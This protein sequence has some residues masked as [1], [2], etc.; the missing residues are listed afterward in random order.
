MI[1]PSRQDAEAYLQDAGERNPGPWI[2]HSRQVAIAAEAIAAFHPELNPEH[3]YVGGLLHDIG[4]REGV[5]GMRHVVDGYTFL[6]HEGFPDVARIC[7]T[8]S[9]PIPN[10]MAGSSLWD[11]T[12]EEK[13]F[14][15]DF[16]ASNTYTAYDKVIQI[17]DSLC[18][19]SGPV[20]MEKRFVDVALRYGTNDL[21]L[22]KWRA[23]IR[24]RA[25][26]EDII[27]VSIYKILSGVVENTFGFSFNV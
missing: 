5:F 10:V 25:E 24:I 3:V 19:P 11:G 1:I 2:D 26:F 7:L 20:L 15:A 8:H 12:E 23:F 13:K 4:R 14:V 18:L 16:L 9:Y 21:M 17:C 27:G 22:E 6:M